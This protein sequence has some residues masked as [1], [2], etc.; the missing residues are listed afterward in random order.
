VNLRS[1]VA[2][3]LAGLLAAC[4]DAKSAG[5]AASS[6]PGSTA[7]AD[8]S[9]PSGAKAGTPA[10]RARALSKRPLTADDVEAYLVLLPISRK[11]G[12]GGNPKAEIEA[13]GWTISEWVV[14]QARVTAAYIGAKSHG[15]AVGAPASTGSDVEV[16][17]PFLDRI[18]AA[19]A[20]R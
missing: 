6:A 5:S 13:H 11:S 17:R 10:D 3:A 9:P 8:A 2:L 4:G 14:L 12:R 19:L 1:P 20:E 16:V 18:A 15:N 7:A